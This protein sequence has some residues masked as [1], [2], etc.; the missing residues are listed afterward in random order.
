MFVALIG[1]NHQNPME[2][3]RKILKKLL[4]QAAFFHQLL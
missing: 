3:Q 2:R 4:N 1:L